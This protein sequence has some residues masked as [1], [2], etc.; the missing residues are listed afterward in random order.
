MDECIYFTRRKVGEGQAVAWVFKGN[1]PECK[2]GVM[3]KPRDEKT[4][5]AKIRAKE[6]VCPECKYTVEKKEYE[7]TLTA[8]I[9]YTCPECK[10]E[11][12]IEIPYKRK[13]FKGMDALVFEC[14]KCSAKI[15]VTKKMKSK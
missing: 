2:K 11:G 15:P 13:K 3:G 6:Y 14:G 8:N 10:H 1:C 5:A 4:G 12:E 9:E 7:E